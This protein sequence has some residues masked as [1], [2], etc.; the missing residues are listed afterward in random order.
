M[1]G[2]GGAV[3]VELCQDHCDGWSNVCLKFK[4]FSV[5]LWNLS[6]KTWATF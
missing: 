5:K 3:K 1:V 4:S 2:G 6:V